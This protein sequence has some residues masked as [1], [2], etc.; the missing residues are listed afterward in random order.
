MEKRSGELVMNNEPTL[1]DQVSEPR[2]TVSN[3]ISL[4]VA[5]RN[6]N[7]YSLIMP[8][9]TAREEEVLNAMVMIGY[10]VTMHQIADFMKVGVNTISGRFSKLVEKKRIIPQAKTKEKRP[11]TIYKVIKV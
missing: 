6:D 10:P 9:L 8:E 5:N 3:T 1:F 7:Y 2:Q 11:K 4:P